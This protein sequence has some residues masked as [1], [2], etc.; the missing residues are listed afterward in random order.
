MKNF[1][2]LMSVYA[3]EQSDYLKVALRSIFA[4]TVLPTE[5]VLVKDGPLTQELDNV[6]A[7]FCE[8][9]DSIKVVKIAKIQ[10]WG[11]R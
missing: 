7:D 11:M 10:D 4:Q 9:Y 8:K 1:S 6:I 2:V 3:R 5:I